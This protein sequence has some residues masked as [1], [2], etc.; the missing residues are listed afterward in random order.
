MITGC[1]WHAHA[2]SISVT[3]RTIRK[4]VIDFLFFTLNFEFVCL[5]SLI[6]ALFC[7][8]NFL[9]R[10][11]YSRAVA[12]KVISQNCLC[13]KFVFLNWL[14]KIIRKRN[15]HPKEA[16]L[17]PKTK[18]KFQ[19]RDKSRKCEGLGKPS[20]KKQSSESCKETSKVISFEF[21]YRYTFSIYLS[22]HLIVKGF[23]H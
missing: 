1:L 9:I 23:C 13:T 2:V 3:E 20:R 5:F 11:F 8:P 15:K 18:I 16:C 19:F 10:H 22:D 7:D 14:W 4:L 6:F 21:E 12:N 17:P